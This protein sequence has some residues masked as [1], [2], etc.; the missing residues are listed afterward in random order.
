MVEDKNSTLYSSLVRDKRPHLFLARG[1]I[2]NV[3]KWKGKTMMLEV[4][5][6]NL[7]ETVFHYTCPHAIVNS[8]LNGELFATMRN[9]NDQIIVQVGDMG[10]EY[11]RE[12]MEDLYFKILARKTEEQR[13][14]NKQ[15]LTVT[16]YGNGTRVTIDGGDDC[17]GMFFTSINDEYEEEDDM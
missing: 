5:S 2:W 9:K 7:D 11:E 10:E 4:R 17:R 3:R 12:A 16:R 13:V 15:L 8:A 6:S 14:G 1:K